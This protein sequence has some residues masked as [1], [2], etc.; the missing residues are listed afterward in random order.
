ME[1]VQLKLVTYSAVCSTE[2]PTLDFSFEFLNSLVS[3]DQFKQPDL[4]KI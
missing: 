4:L 3:W 1:K 2:L